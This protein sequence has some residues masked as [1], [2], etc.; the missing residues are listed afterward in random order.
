MNPFAR[1]PG[2]ALADRWQHGF[3]L[4]SRPFAAAGAAFDLSERET[5]ETFARLAERGILGRIGAVVRANAAGASTLAAMAVP[6]EKLEAVAAIVSRHPLVNHNYE[7][8]HA[9]N[10]WFV[11]TAPD[12]LELRHA[13]AEIGDACGEPVLDLRLERPYH[14]D[15]GFSLARGRDAAA[16]N[17]TGRKAT[18]PERELLIAL[19]DGLPL[20]LE[21]YAE[22]AKRLG[23]SEQKVC[24]AL[25]AMQRDGVLS[26]FGC[27]LNHRE[28]G[29]TANAMAVWDVSDDE[30]DAVG[31]RMAGN[32]D[33]T[34]CYRR[35][36]A[37]PDWPF[38][39]Y[40]MVHG[41]EEAKVRDE[42]ARLADELGIAHA[43]QA[44]LFSRR[45][46]LQ[47][48]ARIGHPAAVEAA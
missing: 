42:I 34:L 29:F 5:L 41:R 32:R 17:A 48:G 21:P 4:L 10:L 2:L 9:I 40:A 46:F 25:A 44:V 18:E 19:Q 31:Q 43:P 16:R 20:V 11:V 22:L 14:I 28:A 33:V 15:L 30:V 26:R 47:R 37:M 1:D 45:R 7:R 36:R 12:T 27:V 35:R 38:N 6:R 8:D 24:A 13:L 23:C 39:L 3:P